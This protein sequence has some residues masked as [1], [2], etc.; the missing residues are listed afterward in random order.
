MAK[1]RPRS[2]WLL[3]KKREPCGPRR[4]PSNPRAVEL[5]TA[6]EILAEVFSIGVGEVEEMIRARCE[7][8]LLQRMDGMWPQRLWV[9]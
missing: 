5:E 6:K 8:G 1:S 4:P 7:E 2:G 9:E 3:L